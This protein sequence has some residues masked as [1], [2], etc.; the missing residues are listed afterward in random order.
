MKRQDSRPIRAVLRDF[1]EEEPEIHEG[2]LE[3]EAI[4]VARELLAQELTFISLIDIREGSLILRATSSGIRA[5]LDMRRVELLR[6]INQRIQAELL[7]QI[8]LL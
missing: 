3:R 8:V 4:G 1:L 5:H 7:R 2:L 6:Q